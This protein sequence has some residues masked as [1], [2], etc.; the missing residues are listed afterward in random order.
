MPLAKG[1]SKKVIKANIRE[2]VKSGRPPKQAVAIA[3]QHA[4]ASKFMHSP[5]RYVPDA[6]KADA[7]PRLEYHAAPE[8]LHTSTTGKR[9]GGIPAKAE[10]GDGTDNRRA[11]AKTKSAEIPSPGKGSTKWG[12]VS[13]Y[14]DTGELP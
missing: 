10:G 4:G 13:S 7:P 2:L 9:A 11:N 12:G 1:K 14:N 5:D 6:V 8:N 3:F